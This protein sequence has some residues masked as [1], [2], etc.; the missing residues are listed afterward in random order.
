MTRVYS[1]LSVQRAQSPVSMY[2]LIGRNRYP[3]I[4]SK[5]LLQSAFHRL[6]YFLSWIYRQFIHFDANFRLSSEASTK[7]TSQAAGLWE[8]NGFF[9]NSQTYKTYLAANN[10]STQ[11]VCGYLLISI[12]RTNV[13]EAVFMLQSTSRIQH[14][15]I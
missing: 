1:S 2:R 14:Q 3:K 15:S 8:G 7:K 11:L 12:L 10:N 4:S 9:V 6:T 5:Y 13:F